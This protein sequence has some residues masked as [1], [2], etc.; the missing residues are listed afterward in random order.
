[1]IR[2][3][4][5]RSK[6][7][8]LALHITARGLEVRAPVSVSAKY[9]EQ[10]VMSKKNWIDKHLGEMSAGQDAVREGGGFALG[11][12][13]KVLFRGVERPIVG[14]REMAAPKQ[15]MAKGLYRG[16]EFLITEN[17]QP[18]SVR[19]ILSRVLRREAEMHM[20]RRVS[21]YAAL[22]GLAP[23]SV[24]I[25]TAFGRWGSCSAKK[26]IHFAWMLMMA[27]DEA[28]DYVAIHELAHMIHADHSENFYNIVKKFCPD[29]KVQRDKLKELGRRVDMEGWKP[30]W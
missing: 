6:R 7:K 1:M 9:I 28:I 30:A 21:H 26:R 20:P 15:G 13:D 22:M 2:Y 11:Y 14:S 18:D 17:L 8:T 25:T 12:G 19:F 4:T 5:I 27:D 10:F 16:G 29:Y 3:R 24:S 23:E